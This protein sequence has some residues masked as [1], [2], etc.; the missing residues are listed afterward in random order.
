MRSR[1]VH[2]PARRRASDPHHPPAIEKTAADVAE[3]FSRDGEPVEPDLEAL[4]LEARRR[5]REVF[6]HAD[7]GVTGA[8]FAVAETGSLCLVTNEG[9][10]GFVTSLPPVHIALLGMERVVPTLS[11]WP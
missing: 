9:N 8:N 4:T 3:L 1:R 11:D 6:L 10:G 2:P 5:L 7:V